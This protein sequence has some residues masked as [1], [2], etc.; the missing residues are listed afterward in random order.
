MPS[1][2]IPA[3]TILMLRDAAALEVLMVQRHHEVEFAAGALVFPGG[4]VSRADGESD[5][6][7]RLDGAGPD[8]VMTAVQV[9]A[10]REAYEECGLLLARPASRR[11]VGAPLLHPEEAPGVFGQPLSEEPGAFSAAIRKADL[12]LALDALTLFSNWQTPDMQR[13]PKRYDTYFFLASA[14]PDQVAVCD[15]REAVNLCW[16][17]PAEALADCAA[18]RRRIVFPTRLNLEMLARSD[19][20]A[21]AVAAAEARPR[22]KVEPVFFLQDGAPM[23]RI[24]AEAGYSITVEPTWQ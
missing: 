19:S 24:P 23:L 13:V 17:P 12:V 5:W 4:K 2:I 11:G 22:M 10:I 14:P 20:V 21:A 16:I 9:A 6:R 7:D 8:S 3:A 1:P 15:G 18:R